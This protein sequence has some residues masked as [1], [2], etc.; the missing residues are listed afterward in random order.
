MWARV[1]V[2]QSLSDKHVLIS[3]CVVIH[4]ENTQCNNEFYMCISN[5][6]QPNNEQQSH[7]M[8]KNNLTVPEKKKLFIVF[9]VR[10]ARQL[11]SDPGGTAIF[12][13][14]QLRCLMTSS[15]TF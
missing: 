15:R 11:S 9:V 7:Y 8:Q 13:R 2:M 6:P 5:K 3:G 4:I 12:Q 10:F 14:Q 1:I